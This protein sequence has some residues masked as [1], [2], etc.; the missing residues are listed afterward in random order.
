MKSKF[1]NSERSTQTDN[2]LQNLLEKARILQEIE[3][4][5][6]TSEED[7]RESQPAMK[8]AQFQAYFDDD[9]SFFSAEDIHKAKHKAEEHLKGTYDQV[10]RSSLTAQQ[11]KHV[12]HTTWATQVRSSQ[13][14][15]SLTTRIVD[16]SFKHQLLELDVTWHHV[17]HHFHIW[18]WSSYVEFD[19]PMGCYRE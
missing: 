5:I 7:A 19:Q 1:F 10:S 13:G 14:E 9:L 11:L 18:A 15:A 16:I 6:N 8:D 12:T 4:V 3:L 17:L 2:K